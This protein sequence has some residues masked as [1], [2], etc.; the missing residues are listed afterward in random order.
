ML[1][2]HADFLTHFDN[3]AVGEKDFV[4]I[5]F[6]G[7]GLFDAVDATKEGGFAGAGGTEHDDF[8]T[9]V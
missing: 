1:E 9:L 2:D 3:V 8:F 6:A 4:E 5:D 7:G